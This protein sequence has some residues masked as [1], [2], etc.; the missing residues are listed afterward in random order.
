MFDTPILFIVFNRP[1]PTKKVFEKIKAIKPKHLYIAADGPRLTVLEDKGKCE[2]VRQVVSN[3]NWDCDVKTLF[4]DENRGCGLGPAEA[5]TWFFDHVDRGI[6][7]EDDCVPHEDFFYYC[8]EL[9]AKYWNDERI[10]SISGSNFQNGQWRGNGSYYFSVHNRIWGWA[11]WARVWKQ[12]DYYLSKTDATE[13][14]VVCERTFK[15]DKN[16]MNYWKQVMLYSKQNQTDN[17]A[18]DFQFMFLQWKLNLLSITPNVNLVENIGFDSDATH[19][20]WGSNNP[21][22]IRHSGHILPLN[23]PE[24]INHEVN[25]DIF[26]F[27]K[28]L[29]SKLSNYKRLKRFILKILKKF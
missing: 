8:R 1:A 18:W 16:Q 3:I 26:Y 6:I 11:T 21:N 7:L 20:R 17:S 27:K 29:Y 24:E 13:V 4:R 22:F 19:T 28:Y 2:L 10:G 23:H 14:N 12:Y 25:A 9:L 5:I 15:Y